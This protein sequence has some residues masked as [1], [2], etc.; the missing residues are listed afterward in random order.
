MGGVDNRL[1]QRIPR[2]AVGWLTLERNSE[3]G[4]QGFEN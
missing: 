3:G 4:K 2:F 1:V